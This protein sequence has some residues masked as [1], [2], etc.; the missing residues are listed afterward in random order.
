MLTNLT[1]ATEL[2]H[3]PDAT[4]FADIM[5]EGHREMWPIRSSRFRLWLRRKYYEA[6]GEAPSAGEINSALNLLEAR[7]QFDGPTRAVHMRVAEHEHPR[8]TGTASELLRIAGNGLS[9]NGLGWPRSP[10]ALAGRLRRAQ[11]PL[12]ALGIEIA[13]SREGHAGTRMITLRTAS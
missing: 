11:T 3:A 13:F 6:T 4:A 1:V 5:I 12:R 7:A 10:R 8:W 9:P 2:F